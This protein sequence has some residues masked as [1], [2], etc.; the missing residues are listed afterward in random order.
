MTDENICSHLE[1]TEVPR[2]V[3]HLSIFRNSKR[4]RMCPKRLMKAGEQESGKMYFTGNQEKKVKDMRDT[5]QSL[6]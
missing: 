1:Q 3:D 2:A 4:I 6:S 5:P